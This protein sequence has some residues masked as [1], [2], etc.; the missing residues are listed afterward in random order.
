M[1]KKIWTIILAIILIG[2]F[3]LPVYNSGNTSWYDLVFKVPGGGDWNKYIPLLIP[4]SGVLLLIGA[5]NNGNYFLGR[6]IWAWVPFL[7]VFY[8]LIGA[9]LIDGEGLKDIFKVIGRGYGIGMWVTIAASLAAVIY[10]P[11]S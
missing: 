4:L 10:T 11:R 8:L 5:L 6:G 9:P 2:C 1:N 3:F 7:T